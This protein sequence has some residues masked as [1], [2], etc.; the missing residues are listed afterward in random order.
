MSAPSSVT[1]ARSV[2]VGTK[3]QTLL[4][5]KPEEMEHLL[6]GLPQHVCVVPLDPQHE[7]NLVRPA[8]STYDT[9]T[10]MRF[11]VRDY[12]RIGFCGMPGPSA[13]DGTVAYYGSHPPLRVLPQVTHLNP[14]ARLSRLYRDVDMVTP[15]HIIVFD[16]AGL[17]ER[18]RHI[19][20]GLH[21]ASWREVPDRIVVTI[22]SNI[23]SEEIMAHEFMHVWLDL[24]EGYEDHREYRDNTNG[25]NCFQVVAVQSFVIDCKVHEELKQRGFDVR[26]FADNLVD[27]LYEGALALEAGS[28]PKNLTQAATLARLLAGPRAA[29][30][31]HDFTP[32]DW[33]KIRYAEGVFSRCLPEVSQ[34]AKQ[35][36]GAFKTHGYGTA[37]AAARLIDDCLHLQFSFLREPFSIEHDL[38]TRPDTITW[39][40]KFPHLLPNVPPDAKHHILRRLI[41]ERWPTGTQV[42]AR[43]SDSGTL[44]VGFEHPPTEPGPKFKQSSACRRRDSAPTPFFEYDEGR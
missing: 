22:D 38:V 42:S 8:G 36:A 4:G 37:S 17:E 15:K 5:A 9:P 41:R 6:A 21:C 31:L 3:T 2:L 26:S 27:G 12:S 33:H 16:A 1:D 32:E 44:A 18:H 20:E 7:H 19:M 13:R 28:R 34:L 35:F 29:P 14:S 40:D 10:G 11:S 25:R 23:C 39:G 43:W 30:E 24:G